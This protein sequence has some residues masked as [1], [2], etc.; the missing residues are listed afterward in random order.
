MRSMVI[1]LRV[2][3]PVL[4]EQIAEAEPSVSTDDSRLTIAWRLA[5]RCTPSASTT[6]R[7][8]G[9]PSGTAATASDTPTSRTSTTSVAPSMSEVSRIA[10]ITTTAMT[11]T[12][13]PSILPDTGD[14]PLQRRGVGLGLPEQAGDVADLGVHAG[15]GDDRRATAAGDRGTAE[16]HVHAV[17][18]PGVG[19]DRIGVLEH[20]LALARERCL[21]DH[22]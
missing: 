4:S 7:I 12:A 10:P 14:L 18:E 20:G 9:R 16:H 1:S 19:G 3:V 15:G 17:A 22:Q 5:I 21:G 13:M 6:E 2:N 8:A 11:T